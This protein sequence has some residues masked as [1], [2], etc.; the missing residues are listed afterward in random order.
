MFQINAVCLALVDGDQSL[1]IVLGIIA[2][3]S[4]V[5]LG[6]KFFVNLFEVITAPAASLGHHGQNDN[7]FFSIIIVFLGGLVASF[8]MIQ[9]R[10]DLAVSFHD[11]SV[12]VCS[13]AAQQNSSEV[14]RDIAAETGVMKMDD[15]FGIYLLDNLIFIPV[16]MVLIWLIL[17]LIAWIGTKIVGSP[18]TLGNLLGSLAYSCLFISIG[19]GLMATFLV[20]A[21]AGL[22]S[23]EPAMPGG[24]AIAGIVLLLYGLVLYL[25][26]LAQGAQIT[27]GQAAVPV[28]LLL[29]VLGGLGYLAFSQAQPAFSAF[30]DEIRSYDPAR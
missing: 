4:L 13:E 19:F 15:Q 7:F 21:V 6:G 12:A 29:V 23:G 10:D 17:G 20:E 16:A 1:F 26:G 14:Y 9:G 22:A 27:G 5:A 28:I 30:L 24:M 25:I 8:L 3:A 18:A 11:Y 2:L